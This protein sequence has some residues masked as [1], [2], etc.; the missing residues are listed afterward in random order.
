M[1]LAQVQRHSLFFI[2]LELKVSKFGNVNTLKVQL[3]FPSKLNFCK[4]F[5]FLATKSTQKLIFSTPSFENCEIN[6]IK[7][8]LLWAIQ[9]HR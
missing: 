6:F 1:L 3:D 4:L 5:E 2:F 7:S 8:D 9:Q